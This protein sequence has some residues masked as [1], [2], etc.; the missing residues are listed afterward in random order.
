MIHKN[1]WYENLAPQCHLKAV[2]VRHE[3]GLCKVNIVL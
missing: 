2:D 1:I 3:V